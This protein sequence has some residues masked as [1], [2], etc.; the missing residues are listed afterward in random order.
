MR[1]KHELNT[2]ELKTVLLDMVAW[3]DAFTRKNSIRYSMHGGTLL[4]AIRHNGFIPWDDDVDCF[5]S[6]YYI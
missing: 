4:G 1:M 3:F 6:L 5:L 2:E